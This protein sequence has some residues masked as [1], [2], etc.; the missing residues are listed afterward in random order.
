MLRATSSEIVSRARHTTLVARGRTGLEQT[1]EKNSASM[2]ALDYHRT[3]ELV[4]RLNDAR[5]AHGPF[6][7]AVLWLHSSADESV[8]AVMNLLGDQSQPCRVFHVLGSASAD[9]SRDDD[10]RLAYAGSLADYHRVIL[11]FVRQG[12]RS[13]W[14]THPEI[15]DGVLEAI[16]A[17]QP[18]F[19]VG[20]VRP[21]EQRP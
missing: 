12:E 15:S 7:L 21:W 13:R 1:A 19:I 10:K 11:G 5:R 20:Q 9:P 16:E 18:E 6:D 8:G 17:D 3:T 2:I 4:E 14:L